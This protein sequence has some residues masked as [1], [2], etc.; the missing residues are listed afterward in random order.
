MLEV[1]NYKTQHRDHSSL[2]VL[3]NGDIIE[4]FL[5]H[6]LRSGAP[7]TEQFIATW[8]YLSAALAHWSAVFPSVHVECLAG[9]HGRRIEKAPGR[10]VGSTRW[11]SHEHNLYWGLQAMCSGLQNVTFSIPMRAVSILNIHG[12]RALLAHGDGEPRVKHP[13]SGARANAE[14]LNTIN[15]TRLYGD[16]VQ[17]ACFGHWHTPRLC[18]FKG[19]TAIFNGAL[20]PPSGYARAAGFVGEKCGQFMFE[21]VEGYPC[22]DVRF[23]EVGPSE[24]R[25]ASL[26][27]VVA[28]FRFA[29]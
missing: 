5:G 22:G 8:K 24:D 18:Y 9:N 20:V 27:R 28:P 26:N 11:D 17:L 1:A 10:D 7:L 14:M 25:D 6:D 23:L 12:S 15:A 2:N 21:S 13:D 4:G 3:L 19:T 29:A 16:E